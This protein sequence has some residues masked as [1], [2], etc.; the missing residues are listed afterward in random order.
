MAVVLEGRVEP[1]DFQQSNRKCP[2]PTQ[3]LVGLAE[4]EKDRR[5]YGAQVNSKAVRSHQRLL[6]RIPFRLYSAEFDFAVGLLLSAL[7]SLGGASM[8]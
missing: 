1:N 2:V 6:F 7:P 3:G 8:R 5:G 4:H